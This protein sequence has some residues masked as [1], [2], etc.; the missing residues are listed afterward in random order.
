[1]IS[2]YQIKYVELKILSNMLLKT[3]FYYNKIWSGQLK[4]PSHIRILHVEQEVNGDETLAIES[5]LECDIRRQELLAKEKEL[6]EK[7]HLE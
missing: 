4:I 6:N 1:M 2:R 7:L 3:L 5:V